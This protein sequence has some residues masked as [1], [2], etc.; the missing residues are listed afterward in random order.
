MREEIE[1]FV[2]DSYSIY[3]GIERDIKLQKKHK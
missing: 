3:H 2:I 1:L